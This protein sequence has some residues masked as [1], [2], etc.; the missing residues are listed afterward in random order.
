MLLSTLFF[1]NYEHNI[2]LHIAIDADVLQN[3]ITDEGNKN[4]KEGGNVRD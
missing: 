4:D 1:Y 2:T 3:Y